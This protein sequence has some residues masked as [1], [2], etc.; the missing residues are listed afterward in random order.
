MGDCFTKAIE[1]LGESSK[2]APG[3]LALYQ[4]RAECAQQLQ[5]W[6]LCR[7][8]AT[9]VLEADPTDQKALLQKAAAN[10]A[11]ES[12]EAALQDARKLLTLD[13]RNVAANR[14]VNNC[15]QALR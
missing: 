8:D 9:V 6:S 1:V 13:P 5:D 10:E 12:F 3:S 14:I 2:T 11:L 15:K 4:R 7:R